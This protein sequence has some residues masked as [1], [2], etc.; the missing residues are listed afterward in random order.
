MNFGLDARQQRL[1]VDAFPRRVQLAPAS[2]TVD[3]ERHLLRWEL[4]ELIPRQ[5]ERFVDKAGDLEIPL[6]QVD[7]WHRPIVQDRKAGGQRL[8]GRDTGSELSLLAF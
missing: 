5:R 7:P 6:R 2:D 4:E 8:T 1:E 3:V